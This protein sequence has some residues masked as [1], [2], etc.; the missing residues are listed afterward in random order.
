MRLFTVPKHTHGFTVAE[1]L[2]ILIIV[3]VDAF[4]QVRQ[5]IREAQQEAI[6]QGQICTL[7]IDN[8]LN[9]VTLS[10]TNAAGQPCLI[11]RTLQ[12]GVRLST[13]STA[14]PPQVRFSYRGTPTFG[15]GSAFT[16][17]LYWETA[18]DLEKKCISL[19][20]GIGMIRA[21]KFTGSVTSPAAADCEI[22]P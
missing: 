17:V 14:T 21:G 8:T 15:G 16:S 11:N 20:P 12:Q 13:N 4:N 1:V 5:S 9:P 19:S 2:V 3:G 6:R 22:T 7:T 10:A 18:P